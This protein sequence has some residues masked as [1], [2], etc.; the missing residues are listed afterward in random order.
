MEPTGRSVNNIVLECGVVALVDLA[1][2]RIWFYPRGRLP[3][4]VG[5]YLDIRY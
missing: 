4:H 5:A 3:R 1:G 2:D